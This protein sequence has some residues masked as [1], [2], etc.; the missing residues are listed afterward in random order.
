M[1][2]AAVSVIIGSVSGERTAGG[3]FRHPATTMGGACTPPSR[4]LS[5]DAPFVPLGFEGVPTSQSGS[6]DYVER[7]TPYAV[8]STLVRTAV[9]YDDGKGQSPL[10]TC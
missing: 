8:L 9:H 6:F 1:V 3:P 2:R 5:N 10:I 4:S 7:G